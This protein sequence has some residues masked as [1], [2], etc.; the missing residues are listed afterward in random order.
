MFC[1]P[2]I[3]GFGQT[4]T[5]APVTTTNFLDPE[6]G[7]IGG[8][9]SCCVFKTE[10]IPEME[11]S[12]NDKP[13]PRGELCIKGP[14]VFQ[15]Y[16]KNEEKNKE[17]FDEDGWLHTGDVV[18]IWENGTL[19]IIDRKKNLF[20]L[21]QGEYISPEKL[22]NIY[23]K[24]QFIAQIFVTGD[25]LR[26]YIVAIIVPDEDFCKMW[27]AKIGLSKEG[28]DLYSSEEFNDALK[29]D[30]E[31]RAENSK[32]NSLERIRKYHITRTPFSIENHLLTP[33]MKL[34]RYSAK[35]VF[36]D[37]VEHLYTDE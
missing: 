9:F 10:D 18:E 19:K 1:A 4:E 12:A 27:A 21:S 11:Y 15:G 13:Y 28:D 2:I 33:S 5:I 16:Y 32:L 22:E 37:V 30:L 36:K 8:P 35:K 7:H 14:V 24:S 3:E 26:D 17:A 31:K 23:N 6:A 29:A 34:M 25:S 20:K